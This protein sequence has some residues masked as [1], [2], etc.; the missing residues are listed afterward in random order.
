MNEEEEE[1]RE[2]EERER[3]GREK[4]R[5]SKEGRSEEKRKNESTYPDSRWALKFC[6][7]SN[8]FKLIHLFFSLFLWKVEV[9]PSCAART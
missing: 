2:K 6:F 5:R 1:D 8:K 7:P 4:E 3:D 9:D